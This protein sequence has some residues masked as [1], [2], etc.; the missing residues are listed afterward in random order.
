MSIIWNAEKPKNGRIG[1]EIRASVYKKL[2]SQ[3]F[4]KN[5]MKSLNYK[6]CDI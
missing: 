1:A 6:R 4:L 5:V 2:R 3:Y